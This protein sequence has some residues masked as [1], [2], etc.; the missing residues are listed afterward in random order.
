MFEWVSIE[1]FLPIAV[2]ALLV[3]TGGCGGSS[4]GDDERTYSVQ[5]STT[6][7]A[8]QLTKAQ[9]IRRMNATCRKAWITIL[10]NFDQYSSSQDPR[11]DAEERF[12]EAVQSSLLAGL[13]FHI[14]DNFRILGAPPGEEK[15][16]EDVIGRFQYAAETGQIQKPPGLHSAADVARHFSDYNRVARVYGLGDCLVDEAH[17]RPIEA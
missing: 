8:A 4:T 6:M 13:V 15:A 11:V 17:L 16:L 9:F 5:A 10:D 14:F 3:A 7:T 2:A 1:R 12:A